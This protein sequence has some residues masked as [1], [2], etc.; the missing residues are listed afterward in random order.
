MRY[1][2]AVRRGAVRCGGGSAGGAMQCGAVRC[3]AVRCACACAVVHV[4][5][6]GGARACARWCTCEVV[7]MRGGARVRCS[8][9][10]LVRARGAAR[11]RARARLGACVGACVRARRP[12]RRGIGAHD[13][14]AQA[15]DAAVHVRMAVRCHAPSV[16]MGRVFVRSCV[17]G[18][19]CMVTPSSSTQRSC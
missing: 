6:R 7:H 11:A 16:A 3:M 4:R 1:G 17:R 9:C 12:D 2:S 8:V 15:A 10:A 13:R 18:S 19:A 14:C 5:V